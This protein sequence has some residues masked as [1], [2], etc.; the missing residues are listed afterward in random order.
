MTADVD[1][2]A[3][4]AED[5]LLVP[6]QAI[7]A[8]REASRYYVTVQKPDGTTERLEVQIGL[9]DGSRTQILEGLKDGDLVMMP[10]LPEQVQSQRAFGPG[11]GGGGFGE[12]HGP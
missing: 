1:I 3:D 10:K 4:S 12:D 8:D 5:A 7:E 9:R 6:N 11:Q 2:V